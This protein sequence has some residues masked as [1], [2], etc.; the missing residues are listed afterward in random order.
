MGGGGNEANEIIAVK[1]QERKMRLK[2]EKYQERGFVSSRERERERACAEG[3][4]IDFFPPG[5]EQQPPHS[6]SPSGRKKKVLNAGTGQLINNG[7]RILPM[8]QPGDTGPYKRGLWVFRTFP[9]GGWSHFVGFSSS[10]I[11]LGSWNKL[12]GVKCA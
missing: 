12:A 1:V 4:A 3:S 7:P 11:Q 8:F 6:T 10:N 5:A 9:A 2:I